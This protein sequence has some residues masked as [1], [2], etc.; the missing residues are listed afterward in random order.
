MKVVSLIDGEEDETDS[1]A[2]IKKEIDDKLAEVPDVK[3][4]STP[5]G[6]AATD[7]EPKIKNEP[8]D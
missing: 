1:E 4:N 2:K 6:V 3:D 8:I 5:T 7:A